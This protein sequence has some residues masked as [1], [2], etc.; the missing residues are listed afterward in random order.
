MNNAFTG[1]ASTRFAA[2]LA[3]AWRADMC[4]HRLF[5]NVYLP[6]R[7]TAAPH[8]TLHVSK[9]IATR[10]FVV[11]VQGKGCVRE[12]TIAQTRVHT[13]LLPSLSLWPCA[14]NCPRHVSG[15]PP[16]GAA[17]HA[18]R[19]PLHLSAWLHFCSCTVKTCNQ[20]SAA[21]VVWKCVGQAD[22]PR[23]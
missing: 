10:C 6:T 23:T 8:T 20:L 17:Q 1:S 13:Q 22:R 5:K 11:A 14:P 19:L 4:G 3:S 2:T 12:H 9:G 18:V 7:M 15:R 16:V 21:A